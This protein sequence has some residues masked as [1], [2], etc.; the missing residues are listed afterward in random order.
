MLGEGTASG[1]AG[2]R[3]WRSR[4]ASGRAWQIGVLLPSVLL[5]SSRHKSPHC[6]SGGEAIDPLG[7]LMPRAGPTWGWTTSAKRPVSLSQSGCRGYFGWPERVH[8]GW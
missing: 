5:A 4:R 2:G 8:D 3:G 6:S 1:Q 7:L